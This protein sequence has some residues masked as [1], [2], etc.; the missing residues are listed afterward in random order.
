MHSRRVG[1]MANDEA[2]R[3]KAVDNRTQS[4][5]IF[6]RGRDSFAGVLAAIVYPIL[7]LIR[8]LS[9]IHVRML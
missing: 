8:D 5:A 7:I 3:D 9:P 2:M 4:M 6:T 1:K